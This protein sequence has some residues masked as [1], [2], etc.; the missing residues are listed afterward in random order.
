LLWDYVRDLHSRGTTIVLTTHYLEEAESLC[1]RIAII[2]HGQ[3]V[4]NDATSKLLGDMGDKVLEVT[5]DTEL[6]APPS[7]LA[8]CKAVELKGPRTLV[9]TYDKR[10]NNAGAVLAMLATAGLNVVDVSTREADL[11]DVFLELTSGKAAN[12]AA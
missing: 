4:A 1:D 7:A 3:V 12:A 8:G 5:I 2:N 11:E 9:I 10:S 6:T